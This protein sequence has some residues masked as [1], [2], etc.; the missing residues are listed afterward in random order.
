MDNFEYPRHSLDV[1]FFRAYENGQPAKTPDFFKWSVTGPKAG[2]L[3]FVTGHPGATQRLETVAK[4]KHRRD[5]TLPYNLARARDPGGGAQ[6]VR[7]GVAGA[8]AAG[9]QRPAPGR[10][11]P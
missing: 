4:L 11:L 9:G 7:R 8:E 6:P 1:A 3:V 10:Q 5:V 2:D